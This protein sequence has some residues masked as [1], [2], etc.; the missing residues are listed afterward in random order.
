VLSAIYHGGKSKNFVSLWRSL[1]TLNASQHCHYSKHNEK[2]LGVHEGKFILFITIRLF[3]VPTSLYRYCMGLGSKALRDEYVE[4][5]SW[6]KKNLRPISRPLLIWCAQLLSA[7]KIFGISRLRGEM[8]A[9]N[10]L[11][12]V[13]RTEFSLRE[14]YSRLVI[15][16]KY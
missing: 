16:D 15:N 11:C 3:L 9:T 1:L 14:L 10:S 6:N 12:F 2:I 7:L 8:P 13:T 5:G 4:R